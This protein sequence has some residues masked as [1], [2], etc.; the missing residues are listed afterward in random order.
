MPDQP[1][2]KQAYL[3]LKDKYGDKLTITEDK[4]YEKLSTDPEY[5]NKL[6]NTLVGMYGADSPYNIPE[7]DFLSQV[8]YVKKKGESASVSKP[9]ASVSPAKS[10][11]PKEPAKE[12][13]PVDWAFVGEALKG[14]SKDPAPPPMSKAIK[15]PE[16][17]RRDEQAKV[18]TQGEAVK[19]A[20]ISED[21][22]K[23]QSAERGVTPDVYKSQMLKA[24]GENQYK[25]KPAELELFRTVEQMEDA[26]TN[27]SRLKATGGDKGMMGKLYEEELKAAEGRFEYRRANL[28]RS[29]A[30]RAKDIDG[31]LATGT[32][33]PSTLGGM[34][35]MDWSDKPL[36]PAMRKE[37]EDE[38]KVLNARMS[39]FF[40]KPEEQLEFVGETYGENIPS[41]QKFRNIYAEKQIE[42]QRLTEELFGG[43][44][45]MSK[46]LFYATPLAGYDE[47]YKK[48]RKLG[49][50]LEA[51]ADIAL[52]NRTPLTGEET[53]VGV[54]VGAAV[55]VVV[56]PGV[57]LGE[58][59]VTEMV[60][61][62]ANRLPSSGSFQ[63]I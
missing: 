41:F 36:T 43:N 28:N 44:M 15:T 16:I 40:K 61:D 1:F 54:V 8:G 47:R 39:V 35:H 58:T 27:I 31:A 11:K 57:G 4:F 33:K 26:R 23:K 14:V 17:I 46:T 42:H 55:G 38:K 10:E 34:W 25:D 20:K 48:W 7:S 62:K 19:K 50:E 29:L 49:Y 51:T 53:G 6:R 13:K 5:G 21:Y 12:V 3:A 45:A 24:V 22:I 32:Y 2:K 56:V 52:L 18:I 30:A 37:M 60:F 63:E 59:T 9:L